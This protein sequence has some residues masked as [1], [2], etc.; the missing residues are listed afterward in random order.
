[1]TESSGTQRPAR[2]GGGLS[3]VL[4][5]HVIVP[6][7]LFYGLRWLG[8]NQFLALLAGAVIPVAGAV[9]SIVSEHR[10]GGLQLFMLGTMGL[11]V[12][13]SF[14]TGS[15]RLLLI[16]NGWGMAAIGV[17]ML[18]TLLSRRPFLYEA[19]R[20]VVDEGGRRTLEVNWNRYPAFRRMLWICSAFWGVACL[21][22]SSVRIVLA[23]TLP[24]DLV[25]A[26]D[27]VLL[28]V[29]V[30]AILAFQRFFGRSYLRRNGLR[31]RGLVITPLAGTGQSA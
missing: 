15:P 8:V 10:I 6:L 16:R 26:L 20:I 30:L 1:M 13:M 17:W 14:V 12:A 2:T 25:P 7:A 23:M 22:D 3:R 31:S 18:C 4:L 29:T 19:T 24:V 21:L 11:T 27:D 5:V 9:R 28:G